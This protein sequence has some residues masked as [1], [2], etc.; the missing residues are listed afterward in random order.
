MT[1]SGL[2]TAIETSKTAN[3]A[4]LGDFIMDDRGIINATKGLTLPCLWM[5]YP[6]SQKIVSERGMELFTLR[7]GAYNTRNQKTQAQIITEMDSL[8]LLV[9]KVFRNLHTANDDIAGYTANATVNRFDN[10]FNNKY[11][12][13]ETGYTLK[14]WTGW[15]CNV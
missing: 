12:G 3:A 15:D 13:I 1:L 8:E 10:L 7:V 6:S 14:I 4:T 11:I 9:D 2:F 5:P